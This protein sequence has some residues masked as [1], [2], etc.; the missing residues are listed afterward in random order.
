MSEIPNMHEEYENLTAERA[1]E[2][3]E[4]SWDEELNEALGKIHNESKKNG[5]TC[6]YFNDLCDYTIQELKDRGFKIEKA[7]WPFKWLFSYIMV[8]W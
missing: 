1:N 7:R 4:I 6:T 8:S 5:A 3:V 2:L